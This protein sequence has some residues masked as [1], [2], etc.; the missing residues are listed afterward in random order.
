MMSISIFSPIMSDCLKTNKKI[1]T[2]KINLKLSKKKKKN[3][4]ADIFTL[5]SSGHKTD[6]ALKNVQHRLRNISKEFLHRS[7]PA[8]II[9]VTGVQ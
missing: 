4:S 2:E 5:I 6:N 8:T 1:R 7:L 3:T 9:S